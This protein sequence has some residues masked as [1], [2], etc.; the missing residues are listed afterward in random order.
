[1]LNEPQERMTVSEAAAYLRRS[2]SFLNKRR[3][4][5]GG[6]A[7]LKLGASVLYERRALDQ[8][9]AGN[10]RHSTSEYAHLGSDKV[11][12]AVAPAATAELRAAYGVP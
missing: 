12:S 7:Y 9:L 6:P 5:G 1:M 11:P 4:S 3:V 8:W 2:P 10:V